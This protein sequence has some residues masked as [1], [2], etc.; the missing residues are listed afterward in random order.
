[1]ILIDRHYYVKSRLRVIANTSG[2]FE[3]YLDFNNTDSFG[4]TSFNYQF[5]VLDAT[6]A[7]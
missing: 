3:L 1:M 5:I 7:L 6:S 2:K 4:S